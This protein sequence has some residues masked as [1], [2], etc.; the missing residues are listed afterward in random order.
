MSA[1]YAGTMTIANE[2][3]TDALADA[4]HPCEPVRALHGRALPV[5][6]NGVFVSIFGFAVGLLFLDFDE[7]VTGAGAR[8]SCSW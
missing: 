4:R 7:L 1:I 5:I 3:T 8:R 6:V 2:R